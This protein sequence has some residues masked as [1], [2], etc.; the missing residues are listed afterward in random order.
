MIRW[1]FAFWAGLLPLA[2]Q[3]SKQADACLACHEGDLSLAARPTEELRE[4]ILAITG[5]H[6]GHVTP[7]PEL[8]GPELQELLDA[9]TS[10][11]EEAPKR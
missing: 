10:T 7:I 9:L 4:A 1:V 5:G 8:S 11:A 6:A 3:A 2:V